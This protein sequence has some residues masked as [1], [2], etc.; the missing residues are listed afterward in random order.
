MGKSYT[1][2][3]TLRGVTQIVGHEAKPQT[4]TLTYDALDRLL[5]GS[6]TGG[7]NGLYGESYSYDPTGNLLGKGA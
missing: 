7:S 4:Q 6:A 2:R 3:T 1:T 5:S